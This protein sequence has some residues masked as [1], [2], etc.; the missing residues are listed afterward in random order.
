MVAATDGNTR[1]TD[2]PLTQGPAVMPLRGAVADFT[3]FR[4]RECLISGGAGTG[5]AQP[6]DAL[7]MVPDGP[8][9]MGSL[10]TG[11]DVLTP[12]GGSAKVIAIHEQGQQDVYTVTTSD[13]AEIECTGDHLWLVDW[14]DKSC[15]Q[16]SRIMTTEEIIPRLSPKRKIFRLPLGVASYR[17]RDLP[18]APYVLGVL[19][20]DGCLRGESITFTNPD[21][22]VAEKV[23]GLVDDDK[24]Q[25]REIRSA[26]D[27]WVIGARPGWRPKHFIGKAKAAAGVVEADGGIWGKLADMGLRGKYS[28]EK[29]IPPVYLYGSVEQR[30][31]LVRGLMDT[32]GWVDS[33]GASQPVLTTTSKALADGFRELVE[34]LGGLVYIRRKKAFCN[35]KRCRDA[36]NCTVLHENA[37]R[38][39]S[40]PRKRDAA[41]VRKSRVRRYIVS[42]EKTGRKECRCIQLDSDDGLYMTN[43]HVVT[44]NTYGVLCWLVVLLG[45]YPG[46]RILIARKTRAS[47]TQTT[48]VTW[49]RILSASGLGEVYATQQRSQRT[50]YKF[51]NGAEVIVQGFD[52]PERIKSAEYDVIYV[53]EGTELALDDWEIA[54]SRLRNG[55]I[56]WQMGVMDCNPGAPTH[57]IR[58]RVESGLMTEFVSVHKDNPAYWSRDTGDWTRL[59]RDY[60][61]NVLGGLTGVNRARL[62]LGQWVAAE[63]AVFQESWDKSRHVVDAASMPKQFSRFVA[64]VDWGYRHPGVIS[65]Y[66]VDSDGV[67]WRVRE[68][69]RPGKTVYWWQAQAKR[70]AKDYQISEW[71]C[72]SARPEFIE[73]WNKSGLYAVE[74][75]KGPGSIMVGIRL[76]ESALA[77]QGNGSPG[78][79]FVKGATG[80][81]DDSEWSEGMP[82]YDPQGLA[83]ANRDFSFDE[84]MAGGRKMPQANTGLGDWIPGRDPELVKGNKPSATEDEFYVYS[85][86]KDVD[87]KPRKEVPVPLYDDG[88][89]TC[90]YVLRHL[91]SGFLPGVPDEVDIYS[92]PAVEAM[93]N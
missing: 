12:D 84:L 70:L 32:D 13:G 30:W 89:D 66:G 5:K 81:Y 54:L 83:D 68:I 27:A 65:V 35:G 72:D 16:K 91:Q 36:Y 22:H 38:F 10:E 87:G 71:V 73:Q 18:I 51:R 78:I 60:Y 82:P 39:F 41:K 56:P 1:G 59:G 29:H 21:R 92:D 14:Y 26:K 3:R 15:G 79:R 24:H 9:F 42:I 44:H 11:D 86:P 33:G 46:C 6:Y 80:W 34:S 17:E 67:P 64:G 77:D 76:L 7:V 88:I 37:K 4:G 53:N 28:Y 61:E 2:A 45:T 63:G 69:Y 31:E 8:E 62:L 57:W 55:K 74:A 40:L 58:G 90:R 23:Q 48:L 50:S 19:L 85:W 25:L 20:G 93:W 47:M 43:R 49:E 52:D 75:E